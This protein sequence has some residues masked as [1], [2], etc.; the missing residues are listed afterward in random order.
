MSGSPGSEGEV[1]ARRPDAE[2][3][4]VRDDERVAGTAEEDPDEGDEQAEGAEQREQD[5]RR[6]P[7]RRA[8]GEDVGAVDERDQ[9]RADEHEGGREDAGDGRVKVREELLQAEEVPRR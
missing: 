3:L 5:D 1:E 7:L 4:Q 2:E 8:H 9:G 6:L